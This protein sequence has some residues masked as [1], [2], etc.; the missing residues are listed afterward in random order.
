MVDELEGITDMPYICR[1]TVGT[2]GCGQKLFWNVVK[3]K[4]EVIPLLLDKLDDTTTTEATVPN[5][6]GRWTVAD[7][8]YNALEEIIKDIPTFDLL[9]VQFDHHG[10]GYCS[11]WQH[12]RSEIKHRRA[13]KKKIIQWYLENN[14]SLVWIKSDLVLTCDC[15]FRHPNGGHFELKK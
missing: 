8:A 5:F 7:V 9:G 1:D 3:K 14:D 15:S 11:Y 12:L 13:F 10:C 4:R 2:Q 6:G